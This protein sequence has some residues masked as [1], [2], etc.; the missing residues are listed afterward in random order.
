MAFFAA[1]T[2]G[3]FILGGTV[4]LRLGVRTAYWAAPAPPTFE[5]IL[6]KEKEKSTHDMAENDVDYKD[7]LLHNPKKD[8][9]ALYATL[10]E[11]SK[12]YDVLLEEERE[13][14]AGD[15]DD[16]RNI[17]TVPMHK[18]KEKLRPLL[19][20]EDWPLLEFAISRENDRTGS[21]CDK[22][23]FTDICKIVFGKPLYIGT[24]TYPMSMHGKGMLFRPNGTLAYEGDFKS[25]NL[26][27]D[28]V[29]YT[30]DAIMM[31]KVVHDHGRLLSVRCLD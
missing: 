11:H 20:S 5:E 23:G 12:L 29:L 21:S 28:G 22:E 26:H 9:P 4:G 24:W 27:G 18:V 14:H 25:H 31:C 16:E 10:K 6:A 30:E 13:G 8:N 1:W 7:M 3:G 15:G 19:Q 17:T 2:T